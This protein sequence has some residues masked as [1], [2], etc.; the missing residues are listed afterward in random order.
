MKKLVFGLVLCMSMAIV[1][2]AVPVTVDNHSFEEQTPV[3]PTHGKVKLS[4]WDGEHAPPGTYDPPFTTPYP[5]VTGWSSDSEA[6]DSGMETGSIIGPTDGDWGGFLQVAIDPSVW[7][8]TNHTISDGEEFTLT[9]DARIGWM[10]ESVQS[11]SF[12][13][14]STLKMKL[15]YDDN[16][17]R[18]LIKEQDVVIT[19]NREG[20]GWGGT[21]STWGEY[22]LEFD[23][24]TDLPAAVGHDIGIEFLGVEHQGTANCW[25]GIDDVRLERVLVSDPDPCDMEQDVVATTN[26]EWELAPV[27][28]N[29]DVYFGDDPNFINNPKVVDGTIEGKVEIYTP[30][31]V[32][33]PE[34]TYYWRVDARIDSTV[35]EG[36]V[37]E[38]TTKAIIPVVT[39]DPCGLTVAA[40]ETAVFRV[41]ATDVGSYL[42][43]R[44]G[45]SISGTI[46]ESTLTIDNVQK[47][48]E[49]VYWCELENEN[50]I[51]P[52]E[53]ARVNL[54]TRRLVARWEFED[55]LNDETGDWPGT[56][57]DPNEFNTPTAVYVSDDP[58]T[59]GSGKS[60]QLTDDPCYMLITDSADFFNFYPQGY[61]INT[62]VKTEQ[63]NEWGT[64]ASK[65]IRGDYY[66]GW[67]LT[68]DNANR[69][70]TGLWQVGAATGTSDIVDNEWHMVTATYDAVTGT[71]AVYVDGLVE[72]QFVDASKASTNDQ[73]VLLGADDVDGA[74]PYA[75][76]LDK[77]SIY[78]YALSQVDVAVLYTN[79]MGGNL[80]VGGNPEYDLNDD[81]R[82]D[83]EDFALFATDWMKCNLVPECM[84]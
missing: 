72:N 45:G 66:F 24:D 14:T 18:I 11:E 84:P 48:D 55:N 57:T 21:W 74:L 27:V 26:L 49:D 33:D 5:D 32:L 37:W 39:E 28:T 6:A 35:Y 15:Y 81:C 16:G 17:A 2:Q 59:I 40:G 29:C 4:C 79:V 50:T 1:A 56:Y 12:G 64:I 58:C 68:C 53:T 47:A 80:C 38:F 52:V 36:D 62:W 76:L 31:A 7:Q 43:K 3:H 25:M 61:T 9:I 41:K 30:S 83:L 69:A 22:S 44:L 70:E 60:L 67:A 10:M 34:T 13:K 46:N 73:P 23:V 54:M 82:V 75:G 71:G 63:V 8:L 78:S 20:P 65:R 77:T 19:T 42:W 51:T